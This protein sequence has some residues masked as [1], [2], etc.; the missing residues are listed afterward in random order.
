MDQTDRDLLALLQQDSTLSYAQLG[1]RVGLSTSGVLARLRNLRARGEVRA[2]VALLDPQAVGL[3]VCAFVQVLLAQPADEPAFVSLVRKMPEVQE[4]HQITGDFGYLLKIRARDN[5]HLAELLKMKIKVL[6][7]IARMQVS[8]V[9]A[10]L[11][12]T[13]AV[14]VRP[15]RD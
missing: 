2:Y 8:I 11:K 1:K 12:E 13:H 15:P 4:C 6:P 5:N 3:T 14:D 7:G 9:L 10:S